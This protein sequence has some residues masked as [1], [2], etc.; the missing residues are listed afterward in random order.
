MTIHFS[1]K[2]IRKTPSKRTT[3]LAVFWSV[4]SYSWIVLPR[5]RICLWQIFPKNVHISIIYHTK[6]IL[7]TTKFDKESKILSIFLTYTSN[8]IIGVRWSESFGVPAILHKVDQPIEEYRLVHWKIINLIMWILVLSISIIIE[9]WER[10]SWRLFFDFTWGFQ[11]TV[12]F[13]L[14]ISLSLCW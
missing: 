6:N 4:D 10:D 9:Y 1:K 12:F 8:P 2:K 3:K 11:G 7:L 13:C 5:A 14:F